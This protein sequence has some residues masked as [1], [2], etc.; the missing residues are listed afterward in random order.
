MAEQA[1]LNMEEAVSS[2]ASDIGLGQSDESGQ[3][4]EDS[5]SADLAA[6]TGESGASEQTQEHGDDPAAKQEQ[7]DSGDAQNQGRQAPKAWAKE[8]HE[9]WGKL[10][11][12]AQEYIE[13][14]ERQ[15]VEGLS[16]YAESAK[17]AKAVKEVIGPHMEVIKAQNIEPAAAIGYLFNAHKSLST[18]TPEQ[19]TAYLVEV[20]KTYGIDI[21]KAAGL[22]GQKSEEPPYVRELRER[23]ERLERERE[24][25]RSAAHAEAAQK[26]EK[27]VAD[28]ADAKDEK[29]N[30]KHPYFDECAE[31]IVKLI[32][33]GYSLEEAYQVAIYAN[34]ATKEK[35]L[36][37][38]A[39]ERD[40][41]L[42]AKAK[43]EAERSRNAS[44]T[45]VNS[46]D[47][48]RETTSPKAKR[49]EDTLDLTMQDIKARQS[50]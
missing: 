44:R 14:R 49:W 28:F 10:D 19:R 20:A 25:E 35:E 26:I 32:Q 2:I 38:L 12:A 27:Q 21:A 15:M 45:N 50:H 42:R 17:F 18:G 3:E 7:S 23:Q 16:Q 22:A 6:G 24:A 8:K 30:P 33:G 34:P 46:R 36:A 48:R 1:E 37:R 11:P 43:Q 47:T 5:T 4:H 41:A 29:G 9:L 31:H 40:D 13:Q 39:K